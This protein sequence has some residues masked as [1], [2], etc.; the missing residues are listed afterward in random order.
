M[1]ETFDLT[2]AI[3]SKTPVGQQEI[4]SRGLGLAPLARRILVLVDGKRSGRDLSA[5]VSGHDDIEQILG[6]LLS[7]GCVAAEAPSKAAVVPAAKVAVS[8]AGTPQGLP[9]PETRTAKDNDMARHFMIN[10]INSIIG[11]QMRISLIHDIFHAKSTEA[12]RT[13]YHAWA[14]SMADHGMGSKRLPELREKL[15]KVL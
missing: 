9:A 5:F 4:Q 3:F 13:V 15:F 8:A 7:Q 6:A 11:Q 10:S 14:A 12:L 1:T 2:T